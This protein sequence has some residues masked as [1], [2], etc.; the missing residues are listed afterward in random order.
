MC[1][2]IFVMFT[3]SKLH[4]QCNCDSLISVFPADLNGVN[5]TQTYTGDVAMYS[6]TFSYCNLIAGPTWLGQ[7]GSFSQT[8]T[9][10]YPVNNVSYV[11]NASNT[12]E[13]FSFTVNSGVLTCTQACGTCPYTQSGNTFNT[14]STF[15]GGLITLSSTT[16]YTT[17]TVSGVG[18]GNGTLMGLCSISC[19]S[20]IDLAMSYTPST[21]SGNDGSATVVATGI[22]APYI[23]SWLP[24]SQTTSTISDL[25]PGTYSV[26][27]TSPGVCSAA[28]TIAVIA[29]SGF[30]SQSITA[31]DIVCTGSNDGSAIINVTGGTPPY[32]YLWSNG[33]TSQTIVGLSEG[34]YVVTA[35]DFAG[36]NT[37]DSV[38]IIAPSTLSIE[39]SET[40]ISGCMAGSILTTLS[41]GTLPYTYQWSSGDTVES[42]YSV[43]VP[44]TYTLTV[45]D[46]NGCTISDTATVSGAYSPAWTFSSI[47]Y[48]QACSGTITIHYIQ[49][50]MFDDLFFFW[51]DS[52]FLPLTGDSVITGLTTGT[53]YC[54]VFDNNFCINTTHTVVIGTTIQTNASQNNVTCNGQT[55][56]SAWVAVVSGGVPPFSY[57]WNTSP[58]QT[59]DSI[60]NLVAGTYIST[61]TDSTGCQVKDTITITQPQALSANTVYTNSHCGQADGSATLQMS[62]GTAPYT[63]SWNTNPPAT[64]A[65]ATG[66]SEGSYTCTVTDANS[67]SN[68]FIVAV[69]DAT[70]AINANAGNPANINAGDSVILTGS[71]AGTY[72]WTPFTGL[73]CVTCPNPAAAPIVTTNYCLTVT[74]TNG[75]TDSSCVLVMVKYDNFIVPNSFSPNSD[76]NNDVFLFK[77]LYTQCFNC[78]IYNRWGNKVYEWEN[79]SAGWDG[80]VIQNGKPAS[81]D[82]YYYILDYCNTANANAPKT[83]TGFIQL[84]R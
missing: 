5:I 44:G 64:S 33:Q 57:S 59:T 71:G 63:Y 42:L 65:T 6:D 46:A 37:L 54:S 39:L 35:S 34:T 53:Y 17:L 16:P 81:A 45:T 4:S 75:C 50:D 18:G 38:T 23:Y 60:A 74:D 76:S 12:G 29:S 78:K 69:T 67:C 41:G 32:T 61:I 22:S 68:T 82:V 21:C 10:S 47:D 14:T 30:T 62:G 40:N 9:F 80:T 72:N 56:G 13:T 20:P 66:L 7:N 1:S 36:C 48:S 19:L 26:T 51:Y 73:S 8:L 15:G 43:T 79:A 70:I 58:A 2:F 3:Y 55:N 77:N 24:G 31:T 25:A 52:N 28:D 11:L 27:V 84:I 83:I 49:H